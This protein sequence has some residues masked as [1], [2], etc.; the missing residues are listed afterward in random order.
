MGANGHAGSVHLGD[1]FPT[2][3]AKLFYRAFVHADFDL[4]GFNDATNCGL[5][6]AG[7]A[8]LKTVRTAPF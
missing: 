5:A 2:Q 7:G 3:R 6:A 8:G 1:H 4:K